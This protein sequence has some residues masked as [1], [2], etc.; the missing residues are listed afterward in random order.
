MG[1]PGRP[2]G[3]NGTNGDR[4]N[5]LANLP[6]F[7]QFLYNKKTNENGTK[8]GFSLFA[9]TMNDKCQNFVNDQAWSRHTKIVP[10]S[11]QRDN[12]KFL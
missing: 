6:H 2:V 10:F 8:T 9:R 1:R 7:L 5:L 3:T 4:A 12:I 11:G